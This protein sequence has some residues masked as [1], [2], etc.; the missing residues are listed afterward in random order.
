MIGRKGTL[1]GR[2]IPV[3]TIP[4]RAPGGS[5]CARVHTHTYP[6][7]FA[8]GPKYYYA[9][10]A[11]ATGTWIIWS[12]SQ[13]C[14]RSKSECTMLQEHITNMLQEDIWNARCSRSMSKYASGAVYIQFMFLE[15]SILPRI[16]MLREQLFLE[17]L[18]R[19][20]NLGSKSHKNL[21]ILYSSCVQ[22]R[23]K[24]TYWP[25][26]ISRPKRA[27]KPFIF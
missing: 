4:L 18:L 23:K 8:F 5:A 26:Q 12:K 25:S 22:I 15:L 13:I 3:S 6:I 10:G 21:V 14:S 19:E 27:N 1:S 11:A 7:V 9:P 24:S 20:H 16:G 17:Q 2:Q